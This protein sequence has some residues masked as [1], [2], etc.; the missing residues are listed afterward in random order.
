MIPSIAITGASGSIGASLSNHLH[1]AGVP[2]VRLV[3]SPTGADCR[4][5]D[6]AHPSA[7]SL[8][9]IE[10]VIH[11]AWETIDRSPE[12][13]RRSVAATADL[14]RRSQ[15]EGVRFLFVSTASI[16]SRPWSTY[17]DAKH[18]A[19]QIVL[20]AGG[21]IVRP[22]LVVGPGAAGLWTSLERLARLPVTPVPSALRVFVVTV[23]ELVLG[24]RAAACGPP[25]DVRS[26]RS[27]KLADVLR[28]ARAVPF[29]VPVPVRLLHRAAF[30]LRYRLPIADSLLGILATPVDVVDDGVARYL[31][32]PPSALLPV[33]RDSR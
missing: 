6:L 3:R 33:G 4:A 21:S 29:P 14:A 1:E 12:A 16:L 5:F 10:A 17:A 7:T 26:H 28:F 8:H 30:G 31:T 24:L 11:L 19:E 2:V 22:G 13:Q 9:G 15:E 20:A 18:E 32:S 27:A 23:P 25:G